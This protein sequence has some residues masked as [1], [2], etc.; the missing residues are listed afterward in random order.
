MAIFFAQIVACRGKNLA[1]CAKIIFLVIVKI[2]EPIHASLNRRRPN[3]WPNQNEWNKC[4]VSRIFTFSDEFWMF[5]TRKK[6]MEYEN[7]N[8]IPKEIIKPLYLTE[9]KHLNL[10]TRIIFYLPFCLCP[11]DSFLIKFFFI[12]N[13]FPLFFIFMLYA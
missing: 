8:D 7:H 9:P 5:S 1:F 3:L 2:T 10:F 4:C 12:L 11:S 6:D 13:W